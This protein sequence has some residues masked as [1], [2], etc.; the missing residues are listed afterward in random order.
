MGYSSSVYQ[1]ARLEMQ[2]RR[3]ES[4]SAQLRRQDEIYRKIPRIEQIKTELASCGINAARAVL[5]GK[6]QAEQIAKLRE[7]S[8][9]LQKEMAELLE[10]NGYPKNYLEPVYHCSVCKDSGTYEI[11]EENRTAVCDCFRRLLTQTAC[12]ELNRS[13]PLA[14]STFESFSLEYYSKESNEGTAPYTRMKRILEFCK[15][16]AAGFTETSE[17]LFM[18]GATGLGKTHLSLAIANEVTKKGFGVIYVS[19]PALVS[20]LESVHFSRE[21]EEEKEFLASLTD[22]DLLIIDD[23]ATEFPSAFGK[24][25]LYNLFNS[26]LLKKK[27]AIINTNLNFKELE[28]FYSPRL[29]SRLYGDFVKLDF[30]GRDVRIT[31]KQEK[32]KKKS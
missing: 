21:Y 18:T 25:A 32:L 8:L 3:E 4:E 19:A 10:K 6:N 23:L 1:A 28:S 12:D 2:R 31:S 16:Y 29:V 5:S 26:R 13:S 20:E 14:L 24:T 11:E 15:A 9:A 30:I 27:P 17:N 7:S 22:C